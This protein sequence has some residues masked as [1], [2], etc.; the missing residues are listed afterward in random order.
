M[1]LLFNSDETGKLIDE[2]A[3]MIWQGKAQWSLADADRAKWDYH[4]WFSSRYVMQG[5][6]APGQYYFAAEQKR[7]DVMIQT[8]K[9]YVNHRQTH[10]NS[11]LR[12]YR[13]PPAPRL[14]PLGQA[15]M[16]GK[17]FGMVAVAP[18]AKA[19]RWRLAEVT[20]PKSP[21][22]DP[23]KPW[24]YEIEGTGE[25]A[26]GADGKIQISGRELVAGRSYRVRARARAEDGRWSRWSAPEEFR[27]R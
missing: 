9:A 16:A 10:L 17:E 18:G 20:D 6:T 24:H 12:G 2:H 19:G 8:M 5:K 27:A 14:E 4:P 23:R 11:L 1:D 15:P 21:G 22:F 7:F 25:G 13:P 26:V 3:A